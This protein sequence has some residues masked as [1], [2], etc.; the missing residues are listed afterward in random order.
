MS[1]L[2]SHTVFHRTWL[3]TLLCPQ[4]TFFEIDAWMILENQTATVILLWLPDSLCS[5]Q[6]FEEKKPKILLRGY[7]IF[8]K[9]RHMS[10]IKDLTAHPATSLHL[11]DE[12]G[13]SQKVGTPD[14]TGHTSRR[15]VAMKIPSRDWIGP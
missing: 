7:T 12:K 3:L 8:L 14:F 5:V 11:Q 13:N 6:N 4:P 1:P 10:R 15:L 2:L 9:E